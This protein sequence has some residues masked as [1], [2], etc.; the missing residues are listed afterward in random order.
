[1]E[2]GKF[3]AEIAV[4]KY[5]D[6]KYLNILN[7]IEPTFDARVYNIPKDEVC[8]YF[9]WR[10]RDCIKN[11]VSMVSMVHFNNSELKQKS[12]KERIEMLLQQYKL[13]FWKDI[14]P[15]N[16]RGECCLKNESGWIIDRNIPELTR[17]RDY[18][19]N[20]VYIDMK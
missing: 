14:E 4:N 18:I 3:Y 9:I 19:N 7:K 2:C 13:D 16:I 5:S 1:M 20:L 8:N 6:K 12:T 17:D 11:A 10:Q 15:E